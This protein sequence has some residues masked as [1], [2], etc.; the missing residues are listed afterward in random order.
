MANSI[1]FVRPQKR[2]LGNLI[3]H[4]KPGG[5]VIIVEYNTTRG[6]FAVPHPLGQREFLDLASEVG[7]LEP[8][9]I[10]RIPSTFLGEMYAG[11]GIVKRED[12][13]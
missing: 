12:I 1:H 11:L 3:S 8:R 5:R 4:V 13:R 2:V 10:A 9:I 7:L 6:N